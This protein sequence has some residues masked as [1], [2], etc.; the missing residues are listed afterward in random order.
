MKLVVAGPD[1]VSLK[2]S[3]TYN[4]ERGQTLKVSSNKTVT[5]LKGNSNIPDKIAFEYRNNP[6]FEYT[7]LD[8]EGEIRKSPE[9]SNYYYNFHLK[10][11]L[12][13]TRMVVNDAGDIN[14]AIMYQPYGSMTEL[15]DFFFSGETCTGEVYGERV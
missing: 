3:I 7:M 11:H 2:Q 6:A 14:E 8:G 4:L 12:G 5:E 13:S 9:S 1:N 10:D 15:A